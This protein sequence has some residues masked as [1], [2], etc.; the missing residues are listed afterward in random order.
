LP[1]KINDWPALPEP[2][3]WAITAWG[4]LPEPARQALVSAAQ[5]ALAIL[6][7]NATNLSAT[8]QKQ[9]PNGKEAL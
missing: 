7:P 8:P 2:I 9:A 4:D 1:T 5:F 6:E 3:R